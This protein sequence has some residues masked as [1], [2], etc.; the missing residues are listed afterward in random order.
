MKLWET[1]YRIN[2]SS[3]R[4]T[5]T[6]HSPY[7]HPDMYV[8]K[9]IG[10]NWIPFDV[11]T[12]EEGEYTDFYNYFGGLPV[13]NRKTYE[14]LRPYLEGEVE[15]LPIN[16]PGAELFVM[17]VV[18]VLDVLDYEKTI[19]PISPFGNNMRYVDFV[20]FSEER[21]NQSVY[22]FKVPEAVTSRSFVTERFVELLDHF[23]LRGPQLNLSWR[24]EFISDVPQNQIERYNQVLQQLWNDVTS[25]KNSFFTGS[26]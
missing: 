17:N 8:G 6:N 13:I 21:I 4:T 11:Y 16:H 23:K 22:I 18:S 3:I 5:E 26:N 10:E 20:Y 24:T 19:V 2:N 15:F 7:N 14:C 12:Y 25:E 9:L 1:A